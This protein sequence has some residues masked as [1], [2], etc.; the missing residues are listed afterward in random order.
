MLDLVK[1]F[2]G[3]KISMRIFFCGMA[4]FF[5]SAQFSRASLFNSADPKYLHQIWRTEDGLPNA[6][7]R[8]VRQSRDGYLWLATDESLVRFDGLRFVEYDRKTVTNRVDRW[9][10]ALAE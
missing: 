8:A 2:S 4:L 5:F 3:K 7:V 10:V 9:C 1:N 6:Y